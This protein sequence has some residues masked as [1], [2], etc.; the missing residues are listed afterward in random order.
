M[1][2][3]MAGKLATLE[4]DEQ[5]LPSNSLDLTVLGLC[6]DASLSS[7]GCSLVRY[8]QKSLEGLLHMDFLLVCYTALH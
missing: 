2:D 1:S 7:V 8:R 6:A 4:L 3:E 5:K